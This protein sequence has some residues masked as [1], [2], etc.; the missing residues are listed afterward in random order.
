MTHGFILSG[1]SPIQGTSGATFYSYYQ[2][3][4]EIRGGT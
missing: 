1:H 3:G 4:E 2:K